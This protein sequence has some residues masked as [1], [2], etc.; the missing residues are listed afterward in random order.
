M[1]EP[2]DVIIELVDG[3]EGQCLVINDY[4]IAGPK[5][6]GGGHVKKTWRTR[7]T[8]IEKAIANTQ[9]LLAATKGRVQ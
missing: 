5:P 1:S 4:R 7:R 9:S 8:D 6:W 2:K 3:C